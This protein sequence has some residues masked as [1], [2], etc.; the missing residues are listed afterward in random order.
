MATTTLT[1]AA[2]SHGGIRLFGRQRF[3]DDLLALVVLLC[4]AALGLA[5]G[6]ARAT[7]VS[8]GVAGRY[9]TPH[10]RDF[11]EPEMVA[12]Q[13][14]PSYR[15]TEERS[16]ILAPGLGRGLWQTRVTLSSPR[17]D[18]Q[19]K[20][21]L[22]R[23]GAYH[24][25]VQLH[26]EPRTFHLL[27]PS[28][29]DLRA[30]I[31]A[32]VARYGEDPRP[33][34]V[35]FFGVTFQPVVTVVM[36][37]ALFLLY[38][39]LASTLAFL[40]LRLIG[41]RAWL[42]L[43][44]PLIG[45][46][47][48]AWGVATNREALGLLAPCLAILAV[49]GL[50][51]VWGA[52]W[53]WHRLVALGK[54]EPEPWLLPA[55][56]A[57]FYLGFWIKAAGLVYP[58]SHAI[59]VAWHMQRT[60]EI[61]D[62]RLADL[63]K[64]GAF[65][66]SV[67][68][69]QEWGQNRPIIP[70]SPFFHIIAASFVIFPWSLE[71][72]ANIFSVFV[73]THRVVLIAALTLAFGLTSRGALLAGLLYAVTPFTFLLHSWGNIPTTFGIWW[74]LLATVLLVLTFGR[75]REPRI[76]V[77][78]IGVLLGTFLCYT[79]MAVFMSV[80]LALL[81]IGL[82]C[83][84]RG[85]PSRQTRALL[86]AGA[87]A[88]GLAVAIYYGQYIPPILERTI[89]YIDRTVVGGQPNVGQA[90]HEPF[91]TYLKQHVGRLGYVA[92]PVRYGLWLPLLLALPGMWLLRR[93]RLAMLVIGS[94]YLVALIFFFVGNRVS[95]VDKHFFYVAPALAVCAAAAFEWVWPRGLLVR[96]TIAGAYVLTFAAAIDVWL[97]RLQTVG[98]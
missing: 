96:G 92:L 40:T 24:W 39:V 35:V 57:I 53:T 4:A 46:L 80:F 18:G 41:L 38:A 71:T 54:L 69:V 98:P 60:R 34:G 45:L 50:V 28:D 72:T 55:L 68:P 79:V 61:L 88:F 22:I 86:G 6:Y 37:P 77:L 64:P 85:L 33:L 70:Y 47:L 84:G 36:P 93:Q 29:G 67:M 87:I 32:P 48:L 16:T 21:A 44:A 42:A 90:D 94:W 26:P 5:A 3:V 2:V 97:W 25:P 23:V 19:P 27:A 65:S 59:D 11:H 1:R 9:N 83:F 15:W 62:G 13:Q 31:S 78:L 30:S 63:Y 81:L 66:E 20:Q 8:I 49:V 76:F 95:M 17:P 82:V 51:A 91:L 89:P 10:L 58:Y 12:G 56:L 74:T 7:D 52:R 73:D 14:A 43:L 75:W